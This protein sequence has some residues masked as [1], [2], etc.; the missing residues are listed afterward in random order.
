MGEN[1]TFWLPEGASTLSPEFDSLFYFVVI[2]STLI[3]LGVVGGMLYFSFV[4]R[5]RNEAEM[6]EPVHDN[7][8]IEMASVVIPTV[9]S[10]IVFTWG[11]KMYVKM[12]VAPPDSY[13]VHVRAQQWSWEFDYPN[14]TKSI[15]E[16]HVPEG[17]PVRLIMNSKDVIHSFFV[18]AF[19]VKMDVLP[20]RYTSVWF[21]AT[22]TGEFDIFCAEYCGTAHSKMLGKVVVQSESDFTNWLASS[23]KG[24]QTPVEHGQTL[25][26]QM[27]CNAC[28]TIDGSPL[29]GPSFKGLFG[30]EVKLA[31]GSTITA[32]ENYIRESILQ[33]GAKVVNGY[34]PIMPA[35]YSTMASEDVD[36]LIAYIKTLK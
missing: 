28:H 17:R 20:N 30:H 10:L 29:V 8:L 18:P 27:T 26:T 12:Y 9:L 24:S 11:F 1:G 35:T 23:Q 15:G 22:K 25:F 3:F 31:D 19:R 33:P 34:S 2:V 14:G 16:L 7:K 5:R 13:Q 36:A 21:N 4:Y 6:P 32:D